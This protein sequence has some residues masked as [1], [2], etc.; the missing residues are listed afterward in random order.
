MLEKRIVPEEAAFGE[1]YVFCAAAGLKNGSLVKVDG[2]WTA[3]QVTGVNGTT[4]ANRPGWARAGSIKFAPLLNTDSS[5]SVPETWI[6]KKYEYQR[7]TSDL[8]LDVIYS[9]EGCVAYNQGFFE[10][11][12]YTSTEGAADSTWANVTV[13]TALYASGG[14]LVTG[15]NATATNSPKRAIFW[16]IKTSYD[17]NYWAKAPIYFQILKNAIGISGWV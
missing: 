2:V 17:T 3:A 5:I 15:S 9:G 10:T 14:T 16:G 1:G 7:E 8:T 4:Y 6:I 13:G 11:D 12:V